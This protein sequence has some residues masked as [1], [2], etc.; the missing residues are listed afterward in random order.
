MSDDMS[1]VAAQSKTHILTAGAYICTVAYF[2]IMSV[3]WA[4]EFANKCGN[5]ITC[6]S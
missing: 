6:I 5:S 4:Y 1:E 2:G 3:D